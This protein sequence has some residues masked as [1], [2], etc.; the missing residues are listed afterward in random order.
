MYTKEESKQ[1]RKKFWEVFGQRCDIV[2]ELKGKKKKWIL[3]DTK[4]TGVDLKFDVGR[5]EAQVTIEVNHRSEKRRLEVYECIEKYKRIIEDGFSDGL[6][7]EF[8]FVRES[9]AEVCRIYISLPNVDIHREKQWP[10]IYNF[11]IENMIKL[12]NNFLAIRDVLKEEINP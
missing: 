1:I 11:F 5:K 9:G 6:I 8:Y 3:H 4:I 12:E 10:D 2:P 7:W